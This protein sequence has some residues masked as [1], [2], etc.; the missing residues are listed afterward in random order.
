[1]KLYIEEPKESLES[2]I[3]GI[4]DPKR[5]MFHDMLDVL[6]DFEIERKES[7]AVNIVLN[8][9]TLDHYPNKTE[10]AGF[11]GLDQ[12]FFSEV[13]EQSNL[14]KEANSTRIGACCGVGEDV[15]IDPNED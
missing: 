13:K 8:D 2:L 3:L 1:M 6:K 10:F 7:N 9:K 12:N 11:L 5:E 14:L 15:Y 4:K